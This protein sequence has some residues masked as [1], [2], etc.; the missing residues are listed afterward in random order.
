MIIKEQV[1]AFVSLV[2]YHNLKS[3]W[4]SFLI[5]RIDG[6]VILPQSKTLKI[7][8]K[9]ASSNHYNFT[10]NFSSLFSDLWNIWINGICTDEKKKLLKSNKITKKKVVNALRKKLFLL[11]SHMKFHYKI[12]HS[13]FY[14]SYILMLSFFGCSVTHMKL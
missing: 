3:I 11:F 5:E 10:M 14:S 6:A 1:R 2:N 9:M 12:M 7:I 4:S 8:Q 13:N